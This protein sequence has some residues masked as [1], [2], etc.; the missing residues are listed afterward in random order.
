MEELRALLDNEFELVEYR[1]EQE[2]FRKFHKY[3]PRY[4][5][6]TLQRIKGWIQD[7]NKN[8]KGSSCNPQRK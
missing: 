2:K 8:A 4:F 5:V 6:K 3:S 7:I 1:I